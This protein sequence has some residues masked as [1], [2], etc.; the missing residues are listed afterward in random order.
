MVTTPNL[1]FEASE[2]RS[3]KGNLYASITDGNPASVV[4]T[5]DGKP[6]DEDWFAATLD[7]PATI[8]RVVFVHGGTFPDGGWFD[9]SAGKPRVQTKADK[10]ASWE[11]IGELQDYPA[12]TATDPAHLKGGEV[13][14]YKLPNPLKALAVRVIGK[15]ACG[16][17]SKQAFA[18]CSELQA[19]KDK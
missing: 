8:T 9:A 16:N 2:S 17:N 12:T 15:P 4:D 7:E 10:D 5:F 18:S 1:F 3:R 11:T 13:F 6:A 19:F 14:T